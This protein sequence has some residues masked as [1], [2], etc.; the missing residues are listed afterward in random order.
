MPMTGQ[1]F[2]C[3][4]RTNDVMEKII[5][6]MLGFERRLSVNLRQVNSC[7]LQTVTSLSTVGWQI[8]INDLGVKVMRT[9]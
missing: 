5:Y 6:L 1:K 4:E 2:N 8:L 9:N 3:Y 7:R